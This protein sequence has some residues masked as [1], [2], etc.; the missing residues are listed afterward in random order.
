MMCMKKSI[1]LCS[2]ILFS[3]FSNAEEGMRIPFEV[4]IEHLKSLGFELSKED[5]YSENELSLKDAIVLFGGGC[6][7][8]VVSKDG[9]I[10]TNHHC[11]YSSIVAHS[12]TNNDYLT[13]GFWANSYQEELENPGLTVAFV[14]EFK[15][16]TDVVL[17]GTDP[18]QPAAKRDSIIESNLKNLE[19]KYKASTKFDIQIKPFYNGEEYY[20]ILLETFKDIRLVGAPPLCVGNYGGDYDNWMWPRHTADFSVF[21]IYAD[22]LNNP[23]PYSKK[24]RPYQAKKHLKIATGGV[25]ENDFTMVYGFPGH[26]TEY[27]S[28]EGVKQVTEVTN[29]IKIDLRAKYLD[30]L[31]SYMDKSEVDMLR[32]TNQ[33][34]RVSNYYKKMIGQNIGLEKVNIA[35]IKL[36]YDQ[37][38]I[39]YAQER[40]MDTGIFR[41]LKTGYEN[42]RKYSYEL[43][44][45]TELNAL[46]PV[47]KSQKKLNKLIAYMNTYKNS[48][49]DSLI[50]TTIKE[51]HSILLVNKNLALEKQVFASIIKSYVS[52]D[53]NVVKQGF[54]HYL[55]V[56]YQ[57]N[58]DALTDEIYN[59][60][61]FTLGFDEKLIQKTK[62]LSNMLE[63]DP[64]ILFLTAL[65]NP[66]RQAYYKQFENLRDKIELLESDYMK[67][68]LALDKNKSFYPDANSTLR[69]TYGKVK[70]YNL[71]SGGK[72]AMQTTSS[73]LLQTASTNKN[74]TE[75]QLIPS[76]LKIMQEKKFAP[77]FKDTVMDLCFTASNHT[78][79]GNSGSP[80]LNAKGNLIGINFDRSWESTMSDIYYQEDICRN[81]AVDIRYILFII[82]NYA[83]C[84][85]IINELELV[86]R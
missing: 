73:S 24:N 69:V 10:F 81:I 41:D 58:I 18:I 48:K 42:Y 45:M 39:K 6:T 47:V 54:I 76:F 62:K 63:K 83:H 17:K 67:Y 66:E 7:G 61:I 19:K 53:T 14:R 46:L 86:E 37:N 5:L 78:T 51:I 36:N 35:A 2:S 57:N 26:T 79:G 12:D 84:K 82:D 32:Y 70:N 85:H 71:F 25:K 29:P 64:Y 40:H 16:V 77:Y 1:I 13:K 38:L 3:L 27:L 15:K 28:A 52:Q 65:F 11:G 59:K 74:I 22:S 44:Y 49:T 31:K 72:S 60:S 34:N 56:N 23:T 55:N 80:V 75:Y 21:R 33:Y 8:E 43:E 50:K 9:L 30:I 68:Q 20:L 4:D